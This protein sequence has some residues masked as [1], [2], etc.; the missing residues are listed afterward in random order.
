[1]A[2]TAT[3]M[4]SGPSGGIP[5]GNVEFFDGAI[6]LGTAAL[7]NI[8]GQMRAMLVISTLMKGKHVLTAGYM[9]DSNF[10]VSASPAWV[11]IVK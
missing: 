7:T 10:N 2:L 8:D 6:S 3:V 1:M 5:S 9:G 11:E 4:A